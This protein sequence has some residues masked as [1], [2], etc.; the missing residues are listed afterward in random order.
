[1]FVIKAKILTT[2]EE[3]LRTNVASKKV[4]IGTVRIIKKIKWLAS[5]KMI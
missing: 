2:Q 5:K 4:K 3:K 1:M